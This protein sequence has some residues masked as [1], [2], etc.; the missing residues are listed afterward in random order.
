MDSRTAAHAL[1]QIAAYLELRGDNRFKIRAYE[2]AARAVQR[3]AADDL[4]PLLKSGA[5]AATPGIGPATLG[6]LT[7]L[8]TGGES[9]YLARLRAEMPEGLLEL[10]RI[11]GLGIAKIHKIHEALGITSVAEL[12]AAA[13][14]GRIA[15]L[16]RFSAKTAA[17]ILAAV[18]KSRA[19]GTRRRIAQ[20]LA[21]A[22]HLLEL[23]RAHP[24]V[25]RAEVAGSV[26]RHLEVVS[27]VDVV[28][29]CRAGTDHVR[30]ASSLA[31]G[32]GVAEASGIGTP[33][34]LVRFVDGTVLHLHCAPES[35]FAVALWEATGPASHA[36]AL[37]GRLAARGMTV[38]G[39][40]VVDRDGRPLAVP[41]EAALF[42]LAG[43]AY[44]E[45]ELRDDLD[46][47]DLA[48]GDALPPLLTPG[49]IRGVL[50]C[51][52]EYSDGKATVRQM[53]AAARARGWE[54]LGISDHSQAA[55]Y[56]GGLA[57]E[58]VLEQHAEIDAVNA[59]LRGTGFRVL[60]GIEAD[61][62]GDGQVD[63][64][65][66][67]LARFDYVIGSVH[68]RFRMGEREMTDRILTALD[69]PWLTVL[70]HPT[71]RLLLSRDP[72]A[73]DIEAVLERA[74]ANGVAVEV[75]ADPHRLDLDWRHVR[76]ALTRGVTIEI[77]PDAH[78][79]RGLDYMAYG[80][81][82]ARKGWC[83]AGDVLNARSAEDVVK[84]A[85]KGR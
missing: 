40:T 66:T 3:L 19:I 14:D 77:G 69:S 52:T 79:E 31:G 30:V 36:A 49:D 67:L 60:K 33:R 2:Q 41:D 70:G 82:M 1:G 44:I 4:A 58:R 71:G 21:E 22:V 63:Y 48:E 5:L 17:G 35:R 80:V 51:H 25:S 7:D 72:Y 10:M 42:R 43:M 11:P 23:V 8:V 27:N 39:S 20:A 46:A 37:A 59:E 38:E 50:H 15:A 74:A 65:E 75:N 61:I 32:P 12:E 9:G 28:A 81:A 13:R 68:S 16:P 78:S 56:A 76:S 53:A 6:V 73:V 26:R 47:L 24:D 84:F 54:Y 29:A 62:L 57:P 55:F 85:R 83:T 18:E 45:P 64:D 34:V